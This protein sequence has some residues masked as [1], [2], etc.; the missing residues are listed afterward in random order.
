MS[1]QTIKDTYIFAKFQYIVAVIPKLTCF[2][3]CSLQ[4]LAKQMY[5]R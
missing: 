3:H 5:N 2:F 1:Q 4:I